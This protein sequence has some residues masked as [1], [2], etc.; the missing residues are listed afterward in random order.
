M[1]YVSI[2][3]PELPATCANHLRRSG[4]PASPVCEGISDQSPAI[5]ATRCRQRGARWNMLSDGYIYAQRNGVARRLRGHSKAHDIVR[6]GVR[7]S[8]R[9]SY[10]P[11]ATGECDYERTA[12]HRALA[13]YLPRTTLSRSQLFAVSFQPELRPD[14]DD[15]RVS[16][17]PSQSHR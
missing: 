13:P 17:S 8:L 5:A 7:L 14:Q 4:F 6:G 3:Y 16:I 11:R 9:P 15:A 12:P 1:L 2:G 10:V